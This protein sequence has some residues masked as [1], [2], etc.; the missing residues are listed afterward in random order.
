MEKIYI[1]GAGI[2]CYGVMSFVGKE[3]VIAIIDN[4]KKKI[5]GQIK[6]IDIISLEDYLIKDD[7]KDIVISGYYYSA[8]IALQLENRGIVNYYKAPYMQ[9]GFFDDCLDIVKKLNLTGYKQV[10]MA[11]SNPISR[12]IEDE[13]KQSGCHTKVFYAGNLTQINAYNNV[14][15]LITN[16]DDKYVLN[17]LDVSINKPIILD[18]V[19]LYREKFTFKNEELLKF[20]DI[21]K[22]KRCFI[23]G[24]GPSLTYEDLEFLHSRNEICFGTNRIYMA[25]ENTAWRPDYYVSI[26]Y[27]LVQKDYEKIRQLSGTKFIRHFYKTEYNWDKTNTY[28]FCGLNFE[29]G[30][31]KM[32]RDIVKGVYSGNTVIYDAIQIALY[33]GFSEIYMLGVDMTS[34]KRPEEDGYHFYKSPDTN[35]NL[36]VGNFPEIFRALRYMRE[37]I[38]KEGRI[39]KNATRGGELE[40]LE[41][42]IFDELF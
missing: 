31:P 10:I 42:V 13:L 8:E 17:K 19:E 25:F 3:N 26:D 22:G 2:N 38:E 30:K 16:E 11:S 4:D 28:E 41:R 21:H 37:Q 40:E 9:I 18:L 20:K 6:G 32:S 34:S 33:M 36:V 15:I 12:G 24:N 29:P 7:N 39:I 27:T 23:I 35:E 5:G 14:P 1:F